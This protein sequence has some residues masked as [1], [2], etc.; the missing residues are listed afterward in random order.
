MI[1]VFDRQDNSILAAGTEIAR[2]LFPE[3]PR[4]TQPPLVTITVHRDEAQT[5]TVM[6]IYLK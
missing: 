4:S 3:L 6:L 1:N 2:S 5:T